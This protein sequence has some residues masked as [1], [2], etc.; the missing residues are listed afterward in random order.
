[1]PETRHVIVDTGDDLEP[2]MKHIE[3]T[4][5]AQRESSLNQIDSAFGEIHR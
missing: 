2:A 1:L 5:A 3:E 4:I